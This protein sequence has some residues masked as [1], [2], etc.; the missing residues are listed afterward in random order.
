MIRALMLAVLMAAA[1]A[2]AGVAMAGENCGHGDSK[3][4]TTKADP[5]KTLTAST[6]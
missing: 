6:K 1:V 3:D 2:F 4:A 5:P